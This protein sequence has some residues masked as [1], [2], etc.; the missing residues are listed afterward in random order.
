MTRARTIARSPT[1][2]IVDAVPDVEARDS[3]IKTPDAEG[4]KL[5]ALT[6]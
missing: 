2:T 6:V 5:R 3:E 4:P 1:E